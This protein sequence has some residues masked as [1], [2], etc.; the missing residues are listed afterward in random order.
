M[1]KY[2][3]KKNY[4]E[5]EILTTLNNEDNSDKNCINNL[6]VRVGSVDL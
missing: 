6:L 4:F 1:S 5:N 3:E 2:L